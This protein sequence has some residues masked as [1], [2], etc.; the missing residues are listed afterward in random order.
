MG[1]TAWVAGASGLVGGHIV[2]QLC[3]NEKY[4]RVIAFVRKPIQNDWSQHTKVE[5]WQVDFDSLKA[6]S[7][8]DK[9]DEAYCALGTTAKKTPDKTQYYKIDV[10][11]P[12]NFAD[13]AL[14]HGAGF[15]GLVS[16]HGASASSL[17]GYLKMKGQLEQQLGSKAF[18]HQAFARPSLLKGNRNEFRLMEQFSEG[19]MNLMPG[20]YKAIQAA[21]VAAALIGAANASQQG[22]EILSSASMQKASEQI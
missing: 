9:V 14:Q 10:T 5:Q 21:D 7:E 8:S 2:S 3:Q 17:S 15:Y 16:A 1:K 4:D 19:L 20:N 12:L 13:L 11:Y 22:I 18:Q 6:A